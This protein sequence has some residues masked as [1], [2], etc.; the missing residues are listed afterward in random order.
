M[1]EG[2]EEQRA[3]TNPRAQQENEEATPPTN[4]GTFAFFLM[5]AV[6]VHTLAL[7]LMELQPGADGPQILTADALYQLG[8]VEEAYCLLLNIEHTAPRPQ[9][10]AR[11]AILQLHRVFLYG[12]LKKLINSGDTSCL[13]PLLSVT[14]L[15]DRALLEK[16][17]HTTSKRIMCGQ[18][19]ES[20]IREAVAYL[21][22]AIMASGGAAIDSL[23]ER[24][25]CYAL[26]GQWKTAIFD[27]IAILKEHPDH[28][29]ALCGR[30]F[31]YLMLNQQKMCMLSLKDK[32]R[33]LVS[34]WLAQHCRSSLS[35]TLSANPVPCREELLQEAFLIGEALMNTDCREPR[36]HL[37]YIDIQYKVNAAGAHLKQVF[38]QEPRDAAAKARW[39][40]VKAWQQTYKVAAN[41]LS[42]VAEKEPATLDFLITL[43]QSVK[44]KRLAQAASQQASSV[45][46]SGQWEQALALLTLAVRAVSEMKLQYLRQRAACLAH[47][48]LH[49]KA[50]SDLNK[51]IQGH[52]A[53]G[54]EEKRVWAEDLCHRGSS[55]LLC[56]HEE[57]GLQD[58][59]QAL[60][61]HEEQALLCV[62]AGLGTQR[63]AEMFLRFTG[64]KVDS[65]HVEHARIKREVSGPCTVH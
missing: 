44:K 41:Y 1:L 65:S 4:R 31:T 40:V 17:C 43:L 15:Q 18:Q 9:I 54:R 37:L 33:K 5:S 64:L 20:A 63:L 8:H 60:D 14:S 27:F 38:G 46:E 49:K 25:R 24:A 29:Q 62:E 51:L 30:G 42:V 57:S 26:L 59:S 13:W 2:T 47:L 58:F 11:L 7:L 28:V 10:L 21:S 55:L 35:E 53:D 45:S 12:L 48:G 34:E 22:I 32:V 19:A 61:L 36:W 16:H 3:E 39:G 56:S 50:V 6:G 52:N 23:L